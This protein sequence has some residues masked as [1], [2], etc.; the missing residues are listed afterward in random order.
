MDQ[1]HTYQDLKFSRRKFYN[2][3]PSPVLLLIPGGF[4]MV[5]LFMPPAA[6]FWFAIL[7]VCALTWISSFGWQSALEALIEF[8]QNIQK[9]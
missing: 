3:I 4:I 7:L 6:F 1:K 8:L 5:W 2:P 9:N